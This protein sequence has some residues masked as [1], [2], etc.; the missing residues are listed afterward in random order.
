M[1]YGH[2][3]RP[4]NFL[5]HNSAELGMDGAVRPTGGGFV[6]HH[7]DYAF[8]FL[9]SS[10]HPLYS[11][12]VLENYY[13]VN[14]MILQVLDKVF[15]VRGHLSVCE[16]A[17]RSGVSNFCMAQ[18]S[19]YDILIGDRKVC[20]AAQRSVKQGFLHQGSIF[21]SGNSQEF[22]EKFFLPEVVESVASAIEARSFFPLGIA[23]SLSSVMEVRG[24]IKEELIRMCS[25]T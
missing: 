24:E 25:L 10:D 20:G 5:V 8:S 4:G 11:K 22:Y 15:R 17:R 16:D 7:G 3:M 19:K 9:V 13:T 6:F 2:F 12:S 18:A 21:L 1:T 23:A 14:R